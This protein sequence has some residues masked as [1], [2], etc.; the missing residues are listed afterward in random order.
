MTMMDWWE[1]LLPEEEEEETEF[2][3]QLSPEGES[4]LRKI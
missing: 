2:G 4:F 1:G 3:N